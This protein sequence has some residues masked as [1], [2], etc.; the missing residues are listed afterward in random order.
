MTIEYTCWICG[1]HGMA[2]GDEEG[3]ALFGLDFWKSKLVHDQC[4]E[5]QNDRNRLIDR[6]LSLAFFHRRMAESNESEEVTNKVSGMLECRLMDFRN[7]I[8]KKFGV[9]VVH[10]QG[11]REAIQN[12]PA[13]SIKVIGRM[14][15]AM[16]RAIT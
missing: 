1:K 16:M 2:E 5:F 13:N 6:I 3:I 9:E 4:G 12:D 11:W 10:E 14:E 7:L 8:G 15:R